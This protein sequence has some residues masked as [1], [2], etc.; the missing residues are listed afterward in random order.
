MIFVSVQ[1][2]EASTLCAV[3]IVAEYIVITGTQL[4][5]SPSLALFHVIG[6]VDVY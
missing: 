5:L 1:Y 2:T 3:C 6:W 4:H